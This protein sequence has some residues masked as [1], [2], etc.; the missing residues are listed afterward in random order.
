MA[1]IAGVL[2]AQWRTYWRRFS[3]AGK[4]VATNQGITLIVTVL[5]LNKYLRLVYSASIDL[6]SGNIPLVESLLGGILVASVCLPLISSRVSIPVRGLLHLPLSVSDLFAI[7]LMSLLVNPYSWIVIFGSLAICYPLARAPRPVPGLLAALLF[8]VWSWLTGLTISHLFRFAAWRTLLFAVAL[9]LLLWM[10]SFVVNGKEGAH[11]VRFS[12]VLPTDLVVRA[13]MGTNSSLAVSALLM[14]NI[15]TLAA[16]LWSFRQSLAIAPKAKSQGRLNSALFWLPGPVGGLAAKDFRYFRRLLDPYL[17]VLAAALGCFY[18]VSATVPSATA[19]S[20]V[21]LVIFIPNLPL[22]FNSFGLD[23]RCGLDRYA[24]LPATGA[25]FIRGKNLAFL[26]VVGAQVCPVN[27]LA[28]WR[29]GLSVGVFALAQAAVLAAT[30]LAWGNWMSIHFP[31]KMRAFGFAPAGGALPE[32]FAGI[33][34][35]SLPAVFVIYLLQTKTN[36]A[37]WEVLLVSLLCS[38]FYLLATARAG[39]RFERQREKIAKAVS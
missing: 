16:T 21:I 4:L 39:K 17:G 6:T 27:V 14:L 24:L 5:V 8:I 12:A 28:C 3:R 22:V 9:L 10:A 11:F 36:Q 1:R 15:L 7:R 38:I 23:T 30:H 32:I 34:F 18:L 37:K 20:I 19:V 13:A 31:T 33:V 25:T 35:G 2:Q 26:I 29:L